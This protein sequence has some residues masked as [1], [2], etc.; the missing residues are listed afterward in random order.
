[1]L[2][3]TNIAMA[4]TE[5][6]L[7]FING[8]TKTISRLYV[9]LPDETDWGKSILSGA[10][11]L[12]PKEELMVTLYDWEGCRID[13][14]ARGTD[15]KILYEA[16][17]LDMCETDTFTLG[18]TQAPPMIATPS[19]VTSIGDETGS[20]LTPAQANT[21]LDAHNRVRTTEGVPIAGWDATIA[22]FA[23]QWASQLAQ[24]GC[25]MA[26][27]PREGAWKQRYGENLFMQQ[28]TGSLAGFNYQKV[29]QSWADEKQHYTPGPLRDF[30]SYP[31]Q[32]GHYTQIIWATSTRLGCGI[33]TCQTGGWNT[34][35]VVCNYN[36]PGN[37]I[38][39]NP[40]SPRN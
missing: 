15:R 34:L 3:G 18:K 11:R 30:S 19:T 40:L 26:H 10:Q 38:G 1:M 8:T 35:L 25:R 13:I 7:S 32:V 4:Q 12:A 9:R 2:L 17:G 21:L 36:P 33:S 37:Y 31:D 29:V 27:R 39:Q 28:T 20:I 24:N 16:K 6:T 14:Q 22:G 5:T 23:Q